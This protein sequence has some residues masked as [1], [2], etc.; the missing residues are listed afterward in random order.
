MAPRARAWIHRHASLRL[1]NFEIMTEIGAAAFAARVISR[2]T[3]HYNCK[4]RTDVLSSR[5]SLPPQ[6]YRDL[7][8]R[9]GIVMPR[10]IR[11]VRA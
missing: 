4:P 1:Y 2:Q 11:V 3:G 10:P 6:L 7:L 5:I 8:H 9:V